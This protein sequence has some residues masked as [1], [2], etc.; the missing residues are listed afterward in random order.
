MMKFYIFIHEICHLSKTCTLHRVCCVQALE[1]TAT[2]HF[3]CPYY[4]IQYNKYF[5]SY[6]LNVSVF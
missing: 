3:T 5:I 2:E 6:H 4:R 1:I